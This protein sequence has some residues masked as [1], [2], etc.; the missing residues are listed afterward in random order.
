MMMKKYW[1]IIMIIVAVVP[2]LQAQRQ[3]KKVFRTCDEAFENKE[4]FKAFQC[5]REAWEFREFYDGDPVEVL[6]RY[7][8]AA[9]NFN[10]FV[11]ADTLFQLAMNGSNNHPDIQARSVL[12][13][14]QIRHTLAQD[15]TYAYSEA[16]ALYDRF[17]NQQLINQIQGDVSEKNQL[18]REAEAGRIGCLYALNLGFE[19]LTDTTYHLPEGINSEFGDM[20]MAV[21][22]DTF[23]FS[24]IKHRFKRDKNEREYAKI[25]SIKQSDPLMAGDTTPQALPVNGIFNKDGLHT[26][27]PSFSPDGN[28]LYFSSCHYKNDFS[29]EISCSL[30]KRKRMAGGDW[31]SP[32]YLSINVD[33]TLYTSTHPSIALDLENN[34]EWLLFSSNRPGGVGGLDLWVSQIQGDQLTSPLNVNA[35]NS[36]WNDITPHYHAQSGRLFFSSNRDTTFALYD[37][38]M[39]ARQTGSTGW[40]NWCQTQNMGQTYNSGY[41]DYYFYL[42]GDGETAYFASDRPRSLKYNNE[43]EACCP[44]IYAVPQDVYVTL[45]VT[46]SCAPDQIGEPL[47]GVSIQVTEVESST[48]ENNILELAPGSYKLKS[49]RQYRI[50]ASH[51]DFPGLQVDSIV[52]ATTVATCDRPAQDTLLF[53]LTP[54]Y[55]EVSIPVLA[56]EDGRIL[57]NATL[58]VLNDE[59]EAV[60]PIAGVYRLRLGLGYSIRASAAC[61]KTNAFDLRYDEP[62]CDPKVFP[63][64][65]TLSPP[66]A[67]IEVFFDN[68]MPYRQNDKRVTGLAQNGPADRAGESYQASWERYSKRLNSYMD[69]VSRFSTS[70]NRVSDSLQITTFFDREVQQGMDNLEKLGQDLE[71]F[72]NNC[73]EDI[74]LTIEIESHCSPLGSTEYNELLSKRRIECIKKYLA[75]D[76]KNGVL[77]RLLDSRIFICS[78]PRGEFDAPAGKIPTSSSGSIYDLN[79]ALER[80]VTITGITIGKKLDKNSKGNQCQ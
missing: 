74:H 57:E 33:S 18:L 65:L 73:G 49:Y 58:E 1:L 46:A 64:R 66:S 31:G 75:E 29:D 61:Y 56:A 24:S 12:A 20:G 40:A 62:S 6:F 17:L 27:N 9:R 26:A 28:T 5:Y 38:F 21:L 2:A 41:N 14:A 47:E 36:T 68:D 7:A 19:V 25:L 67:E 13:L 48:N 3:I 53:Q 78:D 44:D 60:E 23:Y 11:Q 54:N 70:A 35:L 63:V 55:V 79:A 16:L 45:L 76:Y 34:T 4:Y 15:S 71:Q 77:N 72:F 39:A 80:R 30:Y 52:F 10:Y 43:V 50:E 32:E 59:F 51:P 8:T 69:Y 42:T 37:N 22:R